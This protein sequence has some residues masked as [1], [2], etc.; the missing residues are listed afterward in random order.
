MAS[1]FSDKAWAFLALITTWL[2]PLECVDHIYTYIY[3]EY[4]YIQWKGNCPFTFA[5]WQW[6]HIS[7]KG[8]Y[9]IINSK[10]CSTAFSHEQNKNIR[11]R[12]IDPLYGK[13]SIDGLVMDS[14]HKG[15]VMW[16]SMERRSAHRIVWK[17]KC[18]IYIYIYKYILNQQFQLVCNLFVETL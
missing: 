4:I 6:C 5:V 18:H 10:V 3:Y 2:C 9:I 17:I 14:L 16:A 1:C 11:V 12:I 15:T 13:S 8:Y 7:V